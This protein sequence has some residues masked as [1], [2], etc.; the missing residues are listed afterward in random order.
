MSHKIK[1][2]GK[3]N[4][5]EKIRNILTQELILYTADMIDIIFALESTQPT[6]ILKED[7]SETKICK[8][9][10]HINLRLERCYRRVFKKLTTLLQNN[11]KK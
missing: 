6:K 8:I 10:P 2:K 5:N 1:H 11:N 9:E 3:I 7:V 4:K